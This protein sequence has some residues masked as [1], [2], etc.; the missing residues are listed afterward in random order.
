MRRRQ[1]FSDSLYP[2][3]IDLL[4][5]VTAHPPPPPPPP[6]SA[7]GTERGRGGQGLEGV[8]YDP[9]GVD[10]AVRRT[11]A[12]AGERRVGVPDLEEHLAELGGWLKTR[13]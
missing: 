11:A 5:Q 1:I 10:E 7:S 9:A 8:A 6:T 4:A 13:L 3:L 2:D 12:A